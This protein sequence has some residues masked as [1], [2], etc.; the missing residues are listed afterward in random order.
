MHDLDWH[1]QSCS[2]A[3][4]ADRAG[5][6]IFLRAAQWVDTS[7]HAF[8]H[9]S[10]GSTRC[11]IVARKRHLVELIHLLTHHLDPDFFFKHRD[12]FSDCFARKFTHHCLDGVMAAHADAPK[13]CRPTRVCKFAVLNFLCMFVSIK[14]ILLRFVFIFFYIESLLLEKDIANSHAL[15]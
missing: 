4:C 15:A 13:R 8:L 7:P 3:A 9:H 12:H 10:L 1:S 11:R 2:G 14:L 6:I 5:S